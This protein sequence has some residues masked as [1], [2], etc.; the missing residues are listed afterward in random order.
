[1]TNNE[2]Y[3]APPVA[4]NYAPGTVPNQAKGL[5]I[6]ALV[7]GIVA[8]LLGLVPIAGIVVGAVA[9]VLGIIAL[10]KKQP[11]GFALTGTILGGVGLIV[12]VIVTI[13]A[14]I[15]AGAVVSSVGELAQQ[16]QV[17]VDENAG[18]TGS[19]DAGT[20]E[21]PL[22][23]GTEVAGKDWTV[24]INSFTPDA[25]ADVMAAS[26]INSEPEA[27]MVYGLLNVSLAYTGEGSSSVL[28]V[29]FSFV[30][31]DGTVYDAS[32][33]LPE[34]PAPALG[35][36]ELFTGAGTTGNIVIS[37]PAG[38]EGALRVSPGIFADDVFYNTK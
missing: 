13:L 29:P 12:S 36:G 32:V 27:G 33:F 22:A 24:T 6:A 37:L 4:P 16:T 20:R 30:T 21:N 10:V 19:G 28:L 1:M 5:A 2:P 25:T 23:L 17:A 8:F 3:Y 31:T 26:P 34:A 9:V 14:T 7:V 15:V 38:A 11:K 18:T 35:T